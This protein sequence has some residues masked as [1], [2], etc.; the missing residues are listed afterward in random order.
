MKKKQSADTRKRGWRFGGYTGRKLKGFLV[1]VFAGIYFL[2]MLLATWVDQLRVREN[3]AENIDQIGA[4]IEEGMREKSLYSKTQGDSAESNQESELLYAE[5]SR[6]SDHY[7]IKY[8]QVSVAAY[9]AEGELAAKSRDLITYTEDQGG[10]TTTWRLSDYLTEE[11]LEELAGYEAEN[12]TPYNGGV[13][14]RYNIEAEREGEELASIHVRRVYKSTDELEKMENSGEVW[15]WDNQKLVSSSIRE[16]EGAGDYG[17]M[18]EKDPSGNTEIFLPGI[19]GGMEMWRKWNE[20]EFLQKFPEQ[21]TDRN[22]A[23]YWNGNFVIQ[24]EDVFEVFLNEMYGQPDYTLVIRSIEHPWR[25]VV[26]SMQRIYLWGAVLTV[27]CVLLVLSIVEVTFRKRARMEEQQRDFTNAIAHEMK[28]PLAV[29]RGFAENLEEN[30]NEEK[31][32]YYLEQIIGQTEQMDDMVKEMVFISRLD[33]GEY[34][35]VK[36]PVSVRELIGELQTAYDTQIEEKRIEVRISCGEDLVISGDKRFLE[37][38]F[39]NLIANA[40]DHNRYEGKISIDIEK[41]R[42]VIENT[43]E[44]ISPEDLPRVCELFYTRDK[45]RG[46]QEK[47][48]GVGLYLADRIFRA[49]R[50]KLKIANTE[51]GVQ[52]TVEI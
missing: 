12:R 5:L 36:E 40:V 9:D 37:K 43:G 24:R 29:I 1:F 48:L 22:A 8:Q 46:G 47:H 35:P 2:S 28:T 34:R 21:F 32:K 33:Y 42:C 51:D 39:G 31:R 44:K 50:M 19:S 30:T 52:V 18:P 45:S 13:S 14:T 26:N 7:S 41:D 23:G 10:K 11:E 20:N 16:T 17:W 38:A 3:Y 27:A 6:F 49:Y 15:S 4:Y 25:A